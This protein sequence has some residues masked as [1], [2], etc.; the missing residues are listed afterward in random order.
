METMSTERND[1]RT[2]IYGRAL[3]EVVDHPGTPGSTVG[4]VPGFEPSK[5]RRGLVWKR[6]EAFHV[7][8]TREGW[9][10][11]WADVA[12]TGWYHKDNV[13]N[14]VRLDT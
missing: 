5:L 13:R 10:I 9:S 7:A 3:V 6:R 4:V 11:D 1:V 14:M 8:K 12:G 2:M